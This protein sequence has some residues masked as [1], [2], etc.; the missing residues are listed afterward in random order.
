MNTFTIK[1]YDASCYSVWNQFVSEA[2]N[3]TFLFHRDFMEYHSD[4]FEDYSLLIY[5]GGKLA[6][7]LPANKESNSIHSHQG[8][9]Y[10]GLL[11]KEI[12]LAKV[13]EIFKT[14]LIFLNAE[15]FETLNSKE[16]P[17]IYH[18]KPAEE[19]LYA[20]FLSKATLTRRDTL[21]VVDLHKGVT[22]SKGRIEGVNKGIKNHLKVVEETHFESFWNQIMIPNLELKHQAKP[23]HS[24]KE[25]E[26]LQ[27][28][29]PT[30]I[31]QFNVYLGDK[32]VAGTTIFE[33]Q[34]VA[35]AQY[36]S[37]NEE[38]NELGSLDFLYHHLITEIFKDKLFLDFGISNEQ[39]GQKLNNGLSFWKESFGASAMVQDFYEVSTS[40]YKYLENVI[41]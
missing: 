33:S 15:G 11:Y 14:V 7:L 34:Q 20:L 41:V 18:Q 38:K 39:Q 16:I 30:N 17:S 1:K 37:A 26:Y 22:I 31:R 19:L 36:I 32:I 12:K 8:L 25:I 35:H 9:T 21:A 3:A 24:L 6:A 40:S 29:F 13:I 10:G 27:S 5:E 23:V 2:K 28:K 4:R